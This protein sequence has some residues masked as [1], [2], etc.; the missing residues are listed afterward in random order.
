MKGNPTG[1]RLGILRMTLL[2]H[3]G[4]DA[5]VPRA[6]GLTEAISHSEAGS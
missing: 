6:Q 4:V 3:Q 1:G 2:G 5:N